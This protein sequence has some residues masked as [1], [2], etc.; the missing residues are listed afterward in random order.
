MINSTAGMLIELTE[1]FFELQKTI[2]KKQHNTVLNNRLDTPSDIM[3]YFST[4]SYAVG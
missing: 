4:I 1:A 2:N 3:V